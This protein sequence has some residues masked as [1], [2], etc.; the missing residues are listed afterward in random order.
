M[1]ATATAI[2]ALLLLSSRASDAF[3]STSPIPAFRSKRSCEAKK[4][5]RCGSRTR[6]ELDMMLDPSSFTSHM[7]DLLSSSSLT[8]TDNYVPAPGEVTYSKW[9]YY[10]TLALYAMSFPGLWSTI[11][12]STKAKIK[13]KT[14]V[15]PG[16]A[17]ENGK[18]LRQQAGEIMAYM[19]ANNYEVKEAGE[20]ICF[21]G[22]V[23]KSKSQAFFLTFCTAIGLGSLA[24][25]LQIQFQSLTLPFIGTP[26]WFLVVLASPYAGLFYWNS[27]DR[28]DDIRVKLLGADDDMENEI[29]IEGNDEELDRLWR[30]LELTEKGMVKVEGILD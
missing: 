6:S 26:N 18:D 27:G 25:V 11:K 2:T 4:Y 23:K 13:R 16:E 21:Q 28:I 7:V 14:Y 22:I 24:L 5:N 19:K 8:L 20:T 9:S 10:G 29:T 17:S 1:S 15:S 3:T 12:R 30:A